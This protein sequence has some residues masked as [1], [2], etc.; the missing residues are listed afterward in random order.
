[1]REDGDE[2]ADDF[3]TNTMKAFG[4]KPQESIGWTMRFDT[5]VIAGDK[6]KNLPLRVLCDPETRK[7]R[8]KGSVDLKLIE[9]ASHSLCGIPESIAPIVRDYVMGC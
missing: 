5:L 6:D 2:R 4:A 1:M 9:G 8:I 3:E 7:L